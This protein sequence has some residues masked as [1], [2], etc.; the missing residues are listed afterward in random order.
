MIDNDAIELIAAQHVTTPRVI[1]SILRAADEVP[2]LLDEERAKRLARAD[3][4]QDSL[5]D[6]MIDVLA[7]AKQLGCYDALDW[8]QRRFFG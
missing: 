5:T 4:R 8:I 3:Q 2:G 6:Q 1:R 7:A